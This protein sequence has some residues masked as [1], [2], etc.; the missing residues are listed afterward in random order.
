[1]YHLIRLMTTALICFSL[2]SCCKQDIVQKNISIPLLQQSD[3]I[4]V[5]TQPGYTY[6]IT[7]YMDTIRGPGTDVPPPPPPPPPPPTIQIV[8]QP[9]YMYD[10][11]VRMDTIRGPIPLPG[12]PT[13][14]LPGVSTS[15][16]QIVN[17]EQ[18]NHG[19]EVVIGFESFKPAMDTIHIEVFNPITGK[20]DFIPCKSGE[21]VSVFCDG[22]EIG[23]P[24]GSYIECDS[25]VTSDG[26]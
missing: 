26:Q 17:F 25:L 9:G 14:F 18:P 22:K 16:G 6:D 11:R 3:T 10:V 7:V 1:M 24:C 5:V 13:S 20:S 23:V 21:V 8:T 2:F 19:N 15:S 4:N 12:P